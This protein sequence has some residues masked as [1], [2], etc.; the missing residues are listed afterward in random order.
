MIIVRSCC[1]Q[2]SVNSLKRRWSAALAGLARP[3]HVQQPQATS[4]EPWGQHCC[5]LW[6]G[7]HLSLHRQ[8]K[9]AVWHLT[10]WIRPGHFIASWFWCLSLCLSV[11][12]LTTFI[13]RQCVCGCLHLSVHPL[14]ATW[15]MPYRQRP[16]CAA[17]LVTLQATSPNG[18]SL[19]LPVCLLQTIS[20]SCS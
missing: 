8:W 13:L 9:T 7:W 14:F 5:E 1:R 19:C 20:L 6:E 12:W 10:H 4:T 17:K 2:S 18:L 3:Q 11:C 15:L 16:H